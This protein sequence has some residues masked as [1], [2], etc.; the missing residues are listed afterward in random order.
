MNL[1]KSV[2]NLRKA[3][4]VLVAFDVIVTISFMLLLYGN[5]SLVKPLS[6][7]RPMTV[8]IGRAYRSG[9]IK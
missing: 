6:E 9:G 4:W 7:D 1:K 5:P 8:D 2:L 3:V